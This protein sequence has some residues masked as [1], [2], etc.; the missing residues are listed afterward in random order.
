MAE[1][2][3]QESQVN[4]KQNHNLTISRE[5]EKRKHHRTIISYPLTIIPDIIGETIN[6]SETGLQFNSQKAILPNTSIIINFPGDEF[7]KTPLHI[8][9]EKY[10]SNKDGYTYG[11]HFKEIGNGE[12]KRLRKIIIENEIN[13]SIKDLKDK[14]IKKS[15]LSFFIDDLSS[16]INSFDAINK[17]PWTSEQ[18]ADLDSY[19]HAIVAKAEHLV[20]KITDRRIIKKIKNTFRALVGPFPYNS[21]LMSQGINKPYG[22]PGDFDIIEKIYNNIIL[23]ENSAKYF[24]LVFLNNPYGWAVRSRKDKM[25]EILKTFIEQTNL[26]KIN[27][28]NL[29]CGPCREIR[30]LFII[31]KFKP[32][33]EICFTLLDQ[34]G[35]AL[36][37]TKT[38]LN[39]IENNIRFNFV[40]EDVFS[41][42]KTNNY[43]QEQDL[44]YTIGLA[45][46]FPDRLLKKIIRDCFNLL[47]AEGA[48]ILAHKDRDKDPHAPIFPDWFCDWHFIAR[49]EKYLINLIHE[50]DLHNFSLEQTIEN[51]QKII[52]LCLKK[53]SNQVVL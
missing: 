45:D 35:K 3:Q 2:K 7:V 13:D 10:S 50:M 20:K 4:L 31:D 18:Q 30:E 21:K 17:R 5:Q 25:K 39:N 29:G 43:I 12:I 51:T 36:E 26:S 23:S 8:V 19:S 9:W 28:L 47:A 27:I 49:N 40:K 14:N 34:D 53:H 6:I 33:K 42:F 16:F 11:I 46:Y 48:F 41:F 22:Y 37:Y 24:D 52:F 38:C 32:K 15:I 44:I 1:K